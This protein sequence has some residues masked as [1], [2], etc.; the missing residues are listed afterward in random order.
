MCTVSIIPTS[1][2]GGLAHGFRLVCNRDERH[3]RADATAPRW[4]ELGAGRPRAIWPTDGEAGGTWIA[5][6]DRGLVLCLLNVNP[7]P[8]P[9]S[10]NAERAISRGKII[11]ALIALSD[12]EAVLEGV[13]ALEHERFAPFRLL[14]VDGGEVAGGSRVATASWDGDG[15]EVLEHEAGAMCLASSGLGD[16]LVASRLELFEGMVVGA[17]GTPEAQD[18][19]HTHRWPERPEISVMMTRADAR[20]VSVTH[21]E[22]QPGAAGA[23]MMRMRYRPVVGDVAGG[24]VPTSMPG[25]RAAGGSGAR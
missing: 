21:V 18:L 5:G 1:R 22:A 9:L 11:P 10:P 12:A 25:T 14:V 23:W 7:T 19:F 6:N 8:A 13:R 3:H 17:G 2:A 20:T 16:A 4:R 24:K 15:L